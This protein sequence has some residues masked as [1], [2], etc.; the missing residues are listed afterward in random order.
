MVWLALLAGI[1]GFAVVRFS[2]IIVPITW[3]PYLS[4]ATLAGMDA[5]IGGM[6]AATEG[7]FRGN[8]FVSGFVFNTLL[9][10]FLVYLG[11]QLGQDLGL[12]AVVLL[13]GRIFLNLSIIRRHWL[14]SHE[15][16]PSPRP[17]ASAAAGQQP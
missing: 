14:D 3:S 7:K 16:A 9:A 12:A 1:L 5:L 11:E 4:L 13:G 17:A 6:R 15:E 8:V 10:A 2:N